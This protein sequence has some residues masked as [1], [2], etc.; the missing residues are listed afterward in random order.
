MGSVALE[1]LRGT[2]ADAREHGQPFDAVFRR[3]VRAAGPK[4]DL[5][6]AIYDTT[7]AWRR[8]YAGDPATP[9]ETA[10]LMLHGLWAEDDMEPVNGRPMN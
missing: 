3:A 6:E 4:A 5:R 8:A 10:A 2:L 1:R 9:A 7:D